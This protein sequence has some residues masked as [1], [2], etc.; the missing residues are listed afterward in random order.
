MVPPSGIRRGAHP[1]SFGKELDNVERTAEFAMTVYGSA[2]VRR[3]SR[4]H[5]GTAG[6]GDVQAI[7]VSVTPGTATG[8]ELT[9]VVVVSAALG[10]GLRRGATG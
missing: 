5:C 9:G 8:L 6:T 2:W 4:R 10:N 3:T 7:P 1:G